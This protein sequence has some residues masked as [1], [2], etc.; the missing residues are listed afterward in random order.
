MN[1][2]Y[3][4]RSLHMERGK[5]SQ[6]LRPSGT[7]TL[8]LN[9]TFENE[10]HPWL[11]SHMFSPP[12]FTVSN[13]DLDRIEALEAAQII[14][15]A[16]SAAL[17]LPIV[18]YT[19]FERCISS[20]RES[21]RKSNWK[22]R[23]LWDVFIEGS[24]DLSGPLLTRLRKA[25]DETDHPHIKLIE[26]LIIRV[27]ETKLNLERLKR[28]IIFPVEETDRLFATYGHQVEGSN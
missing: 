19:W 24:S 17:G 28:H 2:I 25:A 16:Y 12:D 10:G 13:S 5:S 14:V 7:N 11:L 3:S 18:I 21:A 15:L 4:L 9:L 1:A 20:S 23:V 22:R 8:E 6:T 27:E 26:E